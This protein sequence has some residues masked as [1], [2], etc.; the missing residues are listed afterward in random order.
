[1]DLQNLLGL[2]CRFGLTGFTCGFIGF[3]C[4]IMGITHG[5]IEFNEENMGF[6]YRVLF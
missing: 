2:E 4:G 6:T 5:F 3:L 1:M